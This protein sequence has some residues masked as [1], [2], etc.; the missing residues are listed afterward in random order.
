MEVRVNIKDL[1]PE[2]R[3]FVERLTAIEKVVGAGRVLSIARSMHADVRQH[4]IMIDLPKG[5]REKL[6]QVLTHEV[7]AVL[8]LV[9][10]NNDQLGKRNIELENELNSLKSDFNQVEAVLKERNRDISELKGK[11]EHLASYRERELQGKLNSL[12]H[13]YSTQWS[14]E[15]LAKMG[16]RK[17][18]PLV[19]NALKDL[20]SKRG[21]EKSQEK[22]NLCGDAHDENLNDFVENLTEAFNEAANQLK[23]EEPRENNPTVKIHFVT[24]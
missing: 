21:Q 12:H 17:E 22:C 3:R 1:N 2:D 16:K 14:E 4:C 9:M 7:I 6:L 20:P 15:Q 8:P 10:E 13:E 23:S 18:R 24:F 19:F 5:Y 11:V